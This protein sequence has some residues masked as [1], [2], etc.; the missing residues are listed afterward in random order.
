MPQFSI[1]DS[2]SHETF[3]SPR[4]SFIAVAVVCALSAAA[5]F[6]GRT[7]SQTPAEGT[8]NPTQLHPNPDL[9]SHGPQ[10]R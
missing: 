3:A 1:P 9:N 5:L 10:R 8:D 4:K 7:G 6:A 2:H